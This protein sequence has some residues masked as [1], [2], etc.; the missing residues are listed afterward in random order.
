VRA[1]VGEWIPL[2]IDELPAAGADAPVRERRMLSCRL[3]KPLYRIDAIVRAFAQA[4]PACPGWVL[5]VA[6]SGEQTEALQRLAAEL[7]LGAARGLHRHARR[8]G[9]RARLPP[10]RRLRRACPSRTAPR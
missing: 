10:Q 7:G 4:A 1:P 9:A 5:E 8:P 6:A 3:H 2:G